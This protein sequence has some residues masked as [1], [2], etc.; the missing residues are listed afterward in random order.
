M[1]RLDELDLLSFLGVAQN[2]RPRDKQV[3]LFFS[4]APFLYMFLSYSLLAL[5]MCAM[6][7]GPV[8]LLMDP[9]WNFANLSRVVYGAMTTQGVLIKLRCAHHSGLGRHAFPNELDV[10]EGLGTESNRGLP[11]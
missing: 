7:L 4:K 2:E 6:L 10:A 8:A 1:P 11:P 5:H 3:S 9:L